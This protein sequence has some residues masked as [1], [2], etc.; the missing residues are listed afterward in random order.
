MSVG[1]ARPKRT[2]RVADKPVNLVRENDNAGRLLNS[3]RPLHE[4]DQATFLAFLGKRPGQ[5]GHNLLAI[6][7]EVTSCPTRR[8]GD[9]DDGACHPTTLRDLDYGEAARRPPKPL[10]MAPPRS[11]RAR[12]PHHPATSSP[13]HRTRVYTG[14]RGSFERLEHLLSLSGPREIVSAIDGEHRDFGVRS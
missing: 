6:L 10:S 13:A 2:H 4:T 9:R 14:G 12:N 11:V 8:G 7:V 5:Q 1:R 3:R